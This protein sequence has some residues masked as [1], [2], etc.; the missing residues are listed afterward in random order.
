MILKQ[1]KEYFELGVITGFSAV[2]D[3]LQDRCWMLVIEGK[4]GRSW[5]LQTATKID[6]SYASLDSLMGEVENLSLIH[7]S[8]PTRPY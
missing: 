2:R 7:I 5:T 8:E 6:K 3:P 1:A 4:E